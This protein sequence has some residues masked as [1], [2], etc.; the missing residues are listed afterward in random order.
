MGLLANLETSILWGSLDHFFINLIKKVA[1]IFE[2]TNSDNR[3][4]DKSGLFTPD[5]YQEKSKK[6]HFKNNNLFKNK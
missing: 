2:E 5:D 3:K 6:S 4:P 1:E